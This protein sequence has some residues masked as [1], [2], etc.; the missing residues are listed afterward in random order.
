M[1][2][3]F[4]LT[5]EVQWTVHDITSKWTSVWY[6]LRFCTG[7][8]F[9]KNKRT[10]GHIAHLR[11]SSIQHTHLHCAKFNL[12]WPSGCGE[13]LLLISSMY[14]CNHV[15]TLH[16]NKLEFPLPQG[17]FCQVWLKLIQWFWRRDS[18]CEKFT[19][20]LTKGDQ[21]NSLKLSAQVN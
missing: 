11:N 2:D 10:M 7:N 14:F 8:A 4:W 5:W 3:I 1:V 6:V 19:N 20:R 9:H 17:V 12:N 15:W 21:K 13:E 16:L 18:K